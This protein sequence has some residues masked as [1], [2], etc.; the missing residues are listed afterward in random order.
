[1]HPEDVGR[2]QAVVD[3][4]KTGHISDF[5]NEF[6]VIVREKIRYMESRGEVNYDTAGKPTG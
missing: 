5:H 1:M 3:D 2:I 4:C 6:R